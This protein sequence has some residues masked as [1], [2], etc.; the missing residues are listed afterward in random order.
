MKYKDL[1]AKL[2]ALN[3]DRL[4]DTATIFNKDTEEYFYID[5]SGFCADGALDDGH[6][7]LSYNEMSKD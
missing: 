3:E 6:F 2:Q 1:L 4:N 7:Y 5:N